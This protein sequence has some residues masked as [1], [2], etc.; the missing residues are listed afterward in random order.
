MSADASRTSQ[1]LLNWLRDPANNAAWKDFAVRYGTMVRQW[2]LKRGLQPADADDVTQDILANIHGKM[3]NFAYDPKKGRFRSWLGAVTHNACAD[4]LKR[5]EA[6]RFRPM[7]SD[8][9]A[10]D[11]LDKAIEDQAKTEVL[12]AAME[13][14]RNQSKPRDWAIFFRL[15][16]EG[17]KAPDLA[18]EFATSIANIHMISSRIRKKV[19]SATISISGGTDD[20]DSVP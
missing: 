19:K 8:V 15:N 14:V 5:A 9:P 20:G 7:L 16:F 11:D 3:K 6:K 4:F 2:C 12:L 17:A 1:T 18:S 13:E 10:R